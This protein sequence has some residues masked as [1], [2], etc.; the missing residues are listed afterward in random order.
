VWLGQV[1]DFVIG[2]YRSSKQFFGPQG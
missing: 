1:P 2:E